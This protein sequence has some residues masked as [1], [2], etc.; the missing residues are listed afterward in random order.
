[1]QA[2]LHVPPLCCF[3][4]SVTCCWRTQSIQGGRL[5]QPQQLQPASCWSLET[6]RQRCVCVCVFIFTS[7]RLSWLIFFFNGAF[8]GV[9]HQIMTLYCLLNRGSFWGMSLNCKQR[10]NM[11]EKKNTL[12]VSR[13]KETDNFICIIF[14]SKLYRVTVHTHIWMQGTTLRL[15]G[16]FTQNGRRHTNRPFSLSCLETWL[17]SCSPTHPTLTK[18][19]CVS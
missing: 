1:M 4:V 7:V 19:P 16:L 14:P 9:R 6:P 5:Q 2:C 13:G 8:L 11:L 12:S 3:P 18:K 15:S 17:F 10:V